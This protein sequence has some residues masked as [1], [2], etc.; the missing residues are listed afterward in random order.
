MLGVGWTEM[1]VIGVVALIVI[2]PKDLPIVMSRLGKVVG[3][4]RRMG[5]EFQR[6][7]SKTT[8]LDEIRNL[9]SSIT[10]PLRK[11]TEEIRREFNTM[12]PSGVQPS[13]L[14]KPVDP[15]SESVVEEIRA[16]AGMEPAAPVM[17]P[18]KDSAPM[19]NKRVRKAPAKVKAIPTSTVVSSDIDAVAAKPK[20]TPKPRVVATEP[21]ADAAPATKSARNAPVRRTAT[22][23]DVASDG[24]VVDVN[25]V[26]KRAA[27][28]P[29]GEA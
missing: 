26:R 4:I 2:G 13:G 28:K 22:V 5:N 9:R 24:P 11:T 16:A 21:V 20:R 10:E 8:G 23:S 12:T 18:L 15:K 19:V 27:K 25:P 3:Q 6:E 29:A 7:I 17:L 1:L 14:I